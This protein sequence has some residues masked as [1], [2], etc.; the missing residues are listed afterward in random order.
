MIKLGSTDMAK[1]YVGSTEVSKVYLGS[2]LVYTKEAL[3]YD[4]RLDYIESNGYQYIDT[5]IYGN[6]TTEIEIKIKVLSNLGSSSIISARDNSGSDKSLSVWINN[7]GYLALNDR[8]YDSGYLTSESPILDEIVIISVKNRSLYVGDTLLASSNLTNSFSMN[9]SYGLLRNRI[10]SVWDT[11]NN[12]PLEA[13]I[14]Y[15]KIWQN[16]VLVR[17]YIPVIKNNI[18]YLYDNISSTLFTNSG[19]GVFGHSL[20]T[21]TVLNIKSGLRNGSLGNSGNA[22]RVATTNTISVGNYR[23]AEIIITRPNTSGYRYLWI[24]NLSI[25]PASSTSSSA[26]NNDTGS[27]IGQYGDVSAGQSVPKTSIRLPLFEDNENPFWKPGLHIGETPI[28]FGVALAESNND[29]S[30]GQRKLRITA[31]SSYDVKLKLYE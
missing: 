5:G 8:E 28:S 21:Y 29:N 26:C 4:A 30:T 16:G 7:N 2:N 10:D 11:G 6:E 9:T 14:Y 20:E 27:G 31:L 17:D 3:P 24:V 12:R 23:Y 25:A 19:E 15:C 22:Y 1:A 13:R 18:A